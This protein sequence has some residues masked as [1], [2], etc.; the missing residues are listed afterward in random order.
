M[1]SLEY[2]ET[3]FRLS[4]I[5]SDSVVKAYNNIMQLFFQRADKLGQPAE[6]DVIELMSLLGTL[7]LEIRRSSGNETTKL[8][9]WDMLEWFLTDARNYRRRQ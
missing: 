1:L 7:L 9:N 5:G 3:G 4:L 2:K 6:S 8:D